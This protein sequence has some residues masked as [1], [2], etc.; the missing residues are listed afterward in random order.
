ME[1]IY[2][3][4]TSVTTYKTTL[5]HNPQAHT[6]HQFVVVIQGGRLK[7]DCK[8]VLA[9]SSPKKYLDDDDDDD[10]DHHHH[11]DAVRISL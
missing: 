10:D 7:P 3:T 2:F 4:E 5:F 11:V 8:S 6:R 1:A 9:V